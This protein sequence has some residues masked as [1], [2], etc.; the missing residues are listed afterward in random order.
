MLSFPWRRLTAFDVVRYSSEP[1]VDVI[2]DSGNFRTC[3]PIRHFQD[4][5]VLKRLRNKMT[6]P[7]TASRLSASASNASEDF[8]LVLGGP[9]FQILR[10]AYLSGSALELSRR[11]II[12][13]I[14]V[15]WVPLLLLSALEGNAWGN[16]VRLPFIKDI[17]AHAR[18]LVSLPLLVAAEL[19]VH[20]RMRNVYRQFLDRGLIPEQARA[21]FDQ[22]LVWAKNLRNSIVAEI[23]ILLFVYGVGVLFIWRKLV[24]V[25]ISSWHGVAVNGK[26]NP[27]LAGWW[28]GLVSLPLFQ[29]LFLRWYYRLIIWAGFLWRISRIKLNLLATH[30]DYSGGLGFLANVSFGFMPLLTAQGA[31]LS[32]TIADRILYTGARLTQF[33][34]DVVGLVCVALLFI[35]G[36]LLVFSPQLGLVKRAGLQ[37]YGA[38]AQRYIQEFDLKWLRCQVSRDEQLIG[39]SDIQSLADMGNSYQIIEGMRFVPFTT[40]TIIQ[41]AV[42]LLAPL[43]PLTLTMVPLDELLERLLKII[44]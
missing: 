17:D 4:A 34:L 5:H 36:P 15:S 39:S 2:V 33:E 30:P 19:I 11:R 16:S 25:D 9:L 28:F 3:F 8:S 12:F 42:A 35:L 27:T 21:Q 23:L 37:E 22:A 40:R 32:G 6:A 13:F 1:R 26:L 7:S 44:F 20:Q 38:L 14:A 10:R 24:D 29:L 31:L 18:F 43:L 41:L